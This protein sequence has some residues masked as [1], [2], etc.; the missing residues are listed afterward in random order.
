MNRLPVYTIYFARYDVTI[1][2]I[3]QMMMTRYFVIFLAIV[4]WTHVVFDKNNLGDFFGFETR[5]FIWT[6]VTLTYVIIHYSIFR[7]SFM[8]RRFIPSWV[9]FTPIA[10]LIGTLICEPI[11]IHA[12]IQL[13]A[14]EPFDVPK[15]FQFVGR[16]LIV[17][18]LLEFI[19]ATV[20]IPVVTMLP[21]LSHL[22][23]RPKVN[24][25]DPLLNTTPTMVTFG[26]HKIN[27]STIL[28]IRSEDH[29]CHLHTAN[30]KYFERKR[31]IDIIDTIPEAYGMQ[32]HRSYWIAH[33]FVQG[34]KREGQKTLVVTKDDQTF[35]A[36]RK[37]RAELL[38]TY[39]ELSE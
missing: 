28:L 20:I 1:S 35:S 23:Q 11:Y 3:H 27:A 4:V 32:I 38:K 33:K 9:H 15:I 5:T 31:L 7:A 13:N 2:E 34:I 12:M 39:P 22:Y 30:Q 26:E 18:A 21:S 6:S 19:F 24:D 17:L 10:S 8:I 37:L 36:S 14:F 16:D 29:Y 25:V